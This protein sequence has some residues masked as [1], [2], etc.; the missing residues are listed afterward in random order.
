MDGGLE[1]RHRGVERV[2]VSQNESQRSHDRV[3]T[4][5]VRR[6]EVNSGENGIIVDQ[7][8]EHGRIRTSVERV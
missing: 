6:H 2:T 3:V 1:R 5:W 7:R 4:Q 8:K